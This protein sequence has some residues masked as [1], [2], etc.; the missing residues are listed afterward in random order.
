[1]T[2]EEAIDLI[3]AGRM[4]DGLRYLSAEL[5]L[6]W[7][8]DRLLTKDIEERRDILALLESSV[9]ADAKDGVTTPSRLAAYREAM[10]AIRQEALAGTEV[11]RLRSLFVRCGWRPLAMFQVGGGPDL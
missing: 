7:G 4:S 2:A 8:G 10:V 1:M 9:V 6:L 5:F 3:D 11:R